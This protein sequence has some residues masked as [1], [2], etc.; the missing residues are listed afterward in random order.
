MRRR[1]NPSSARTRNIVR[2]AQIGGVAALT[3]L[4]IDS[5]ISRIPA[6]NGSSFVRGITRLAAGGGLAYLASARKTIPD[7][8]PQGIVGGAVLMTALDVGTSLISR[9][10]G[11]PALPGPAAAVLAAGQPW[12]PQL[13]A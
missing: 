7:I 11:L 2:G 3:V 8:V 12:P 10:A 5:V 1:R 4:V 9:P 6:L 13:M